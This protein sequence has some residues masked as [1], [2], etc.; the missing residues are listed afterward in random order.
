MFIHSKRSIIFRSADGVQ[1]FAVKRE[2]VGPVPAW[3]AD[4]RYFAQNVRAGIITVTA[5]DKP[6]EPKEPEEPEKTEKESK[7][8]ASENDA[9]VADSVA[10]DP[11]VEG[12]DG[13][14]EAPKK[15][16]TSRKS[17]AE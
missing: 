16:R 2:Y 3:V 6:K 15:A 14:V 13:E 7:G 17:K 4:T 8:K 11:D 9:A 5:E 10:K 1:T 12:L